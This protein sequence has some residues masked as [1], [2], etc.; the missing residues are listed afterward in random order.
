M[1]LPVDAELSGNLVQDSLQV[2][3]I[4]EKYV[5]ASGG[6]ALAEITTEFRKG[7]LVRGSTGQVP[8][9]IRSKAGGKW[10][11]E[12]VFA[13]GDRVVYVSNG[14]N[15]WE[16]DTR[17]ITDLKPE[18]FLYL[19]MLLDIHAPL[20][21]REFYPEMVI[22]GSEMVGDR[23]A[24]ILAAK[25]REGLNTELSFDKETGLLLRA[26][27]MYFEDYRDVGKVKRPYRI[28]L[29]D[30]SDENNPRL[31][32]RFMKISHDQDIDDSYFSEPI[33]L[34]APK[35]S[36]IYIEWKETLPDTSA[37]KECTGE[38]QYAPGYN[39]IITR[40]QDHLFFKINDEGIKYEIRPASAI[41]YFIKY[42]NL[43]FHFVR[44]ST[45]L[46]SHLELGPDR[47]RQAV[48]V[49]NTGE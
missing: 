11:Y 17:Q 5:Q 16:Q 48:R 29:G 28:L 30:G 22:A 1:S 23:H 42:I 21:I 9:E 18:D 14:F 25:S 26:G 15:G 47:T 39:L 12:Q 41:D 7:T 19:R 2:T 8:F 40:E 35:D 34:L 32:M 24:V 33:C 4:I 3:R 31:V 10:Y 38:Y 13:W 45:G 27:E 36:P 44:D 37:M 46:V 49:V 6:D 43:S 20:R